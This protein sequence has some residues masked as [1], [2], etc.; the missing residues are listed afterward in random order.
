MERPQ[1]RSRFRKSRIITMSPPLA[2]AF[3][4]SDTLLIQCLELWRS[5]GHAVTVVAT[6]TQ[7]VRD[8]CAANQLPCVDAD[9]DLVGALGTA[10]CDYLFAVTWL[11]LLPSAALQLP[12]TAAVNFHDGPL[13][14]YAGLN[15]TCWSLLHGETEH[16]VTWH[17][18]EPEA[19]VG[20]LLVQASFAIEPQDTAFTLNARCFDYGQRSFEELCGQLEG[21]GP[22]RREVD[23]PEAVR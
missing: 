19:D 9:Q 20:D 16:A 15:A 22:A 14:R 23:R 17:V 4:G 11:H 7:K 6:D 12:R 21:G 3:I 18:I 13:P 1:T 5:R 8:Y 10:P 2:A